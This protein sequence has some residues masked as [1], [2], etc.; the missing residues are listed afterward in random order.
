MVFAGHLPEVEGLSGRVGQQSEHEDDGV[1]V[2]KAVRVDV[3]AQ[4]GDALAAVGAAP[5]VT[6]TT[7]GNP[8]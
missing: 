5:A 3:S 1:G 7:G 4:R 8:R 6:V 2:R